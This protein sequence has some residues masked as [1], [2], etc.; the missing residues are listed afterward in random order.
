MVGELGIIRAR[1]TTNGDLMDT[2][3]FPIHGSLEILMDLNFINP[4]EAL[5]NWNKT[6]PQFTLGD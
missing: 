3:D 4:L 2:V 5:E 1:R 6:G